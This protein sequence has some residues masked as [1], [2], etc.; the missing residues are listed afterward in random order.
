MSHQYS[1]RSSPP[2]AWQICLSEFSLSPI[3]APP[4]HLPAIEHVRL[5]ARMSAAEEDDVVGD[6]LV[7]EGLEASQEQRLR[8]IKIAASLIPNV[9]ILASPDE[10]LSFVGAHR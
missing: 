8:A 3:V 10:L 7:S 1:G 2:P 9:S 6:A 4:L 5:L